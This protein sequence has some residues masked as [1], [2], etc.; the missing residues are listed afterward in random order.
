MAPEPFPSARPP[1]PLNIP[2]CDQCVTVKVINGGY[3][4]GPFIDVLLYP[5][6]KG[7]DTYEGPSYS[8]LIEHVAEGQSRRLLFDLGIR[9]DWQELSP[10]TAERIRQAQWNITVDGNIEDILERG[11]TSRND[12]EA[13]IWR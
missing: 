6:I 10:V 4:K 3:T 11:G 1:P 9:K 7:H 5:H 2:D 13:V 8:F 12:I